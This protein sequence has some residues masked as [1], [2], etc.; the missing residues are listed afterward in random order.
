MPK[1]KNEVKVTIV[2]YEEEVKERIYSNYVIV[3]HSPFD[4]SLE[5]C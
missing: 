1:Q 3:R 4:F 5:F 2:P